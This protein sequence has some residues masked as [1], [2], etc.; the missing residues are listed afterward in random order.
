MNVTKDE[1]F[2]IKLYEEAKASG[3]PYNCKDQLAIGSAIGLSEKVVVPMVNLLAQ[4]NFVKKV[5]ERGISLTT[6]GEDLVKSI[7]KI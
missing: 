3:S 4:A 6:R 1:R 5:G 2:L 7:L